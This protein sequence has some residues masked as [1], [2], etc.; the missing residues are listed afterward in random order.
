MLRLLVEETGR[1]ERH[2]EVAVCGGA[3]LEALLLALTRQALVLVAYLGGRLGAHHQLH[4]LL[5]QALDAHAVV[6]GTLVRIDEHLIS[7]IHS[8]MHSFIDLLATN[9]RAM[10]VSNPPS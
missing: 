1:V 9:K 4:A 2:G 7:F 3:L 10:R 6:D 8:F 5:E